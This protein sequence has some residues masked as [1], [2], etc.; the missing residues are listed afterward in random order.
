MQQ[1]RGN[2]TRGI[3]ELLPLVGHVQVAAPP[4]PRR[5][6]AQVPRRGEPDT[7]GEL[8]CRHLLATLAAAQYKGWVGLEYTPVGGTEE[9]LAWVR[10]W[11]YEL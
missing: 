6:V 10:R 3:K 7:P 2:I 4:P 9:G 1:I 11:G 5:Q 8:D